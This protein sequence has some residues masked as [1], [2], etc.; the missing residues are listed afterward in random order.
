M[1]G[2]TWLFLGA[3]WTCRRPH[4]IEHRDTVASRGTSQNDVSTVR[5]DERE[6]TCV[7]GRRHACTSERDCFPSRTCKHTPD[8][9]VR[10]PHPRL[11]SSEHKETRLVAKLEGDCEP[12]TAKRVRRAHSAQR[13]QSGEEGAEGARVRAVPGCC[14][15]F[16]EMPIDVSV[17]G[18]R[19]LGLCK[20][21]G[22]RVGSE[23]W[24]THAV[25][26]IK[27]Q[28]HAAGWMVTRQQQQ[29]Q[30][31]PREDEAF[32]THQRERRAE[33]D[34]TAP[35]TAESHAKQRT[36]ASNGKKLRRAI[37]P[38]VDPKDFGR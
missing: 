6:R 5:T 13:A 26:N 22:M 32:V 17:W 1:N 38:R 23:C 10:R 25:S 30:C 28:A 15:P 31:L 18:Q 7:Y 2:F 12:H 9:S 20:S 3:T 33:R 19:D 8:R 24:L 4:P 16:H 36:E 21:L 29:F 35:I 14:A 11:C 34:H 37:A 27:Q